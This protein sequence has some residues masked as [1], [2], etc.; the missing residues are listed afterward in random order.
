MSRLQ[1][2]DGE[3]LRVRENA[4]VL[5]ERDSYTGRAIEI[6]QEEGDLLES[7]LRRES[8]T[9]QKEMRCLHVFLENSLRTQV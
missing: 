4:E 9:R 6:S 7:E 1:K 5:W 8:D 2:W 3:G